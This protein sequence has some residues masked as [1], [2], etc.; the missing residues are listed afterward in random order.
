[1]IKVCA[2]CKKRLPAGL[3]DGHT[4][5]LITHGICDECAELLLTDRRRP[6]REF[7]DSLEE[8]VFLVNSE[9]R[10]MSANKAAQRVVG[11][12]Q[13]DI[14]DQLGGDV[15]ECANADL[16]GGCGKTERCRAC[17][18]RNTVMDTLASGHGVSCATAYQDI[19]TAAGAQR[20][21]F[22]ISTER[23]GAGVL[24]RIDSVG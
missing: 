16:P 5:G 1:V 19:K 7:L 9:G 14:E 4:D 11:K 8:A 20:M 13:S 10:V 22:L 12:D 18:I 21:R 6:I 17:T 15:F 24:L 2:W 23:V 3:A